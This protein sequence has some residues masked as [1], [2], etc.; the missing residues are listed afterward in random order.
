MPLKLPSFGTPIVLLTPVRNT[1]MEVKVIKSYLM[2]LFIASFLFSLQSEAKALH[3]KDS[4]V[5]K[6]ASLNKKQVKVN[7]IKTSG[8]SKKIAA[9]KPK[10]GKAQKKVVLV[11]AKKSKAA[12]RKVVR[13]DFEKK[14]TLNAKVKPRKELKKIAKME[15]AQKKTFKSIS[16]QDG[17]IVG[18]KAFC[19]TTAKT[20]PLKK[21]KGTRTLASEKSLDETKLK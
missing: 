5:K 20:Q 7:N 3:K 8:K 17:F 15:K 2:V 10:K 1:F 11:K 21:N 18:Q 9:V 19:A 6:S 16:C 4:A 12:P 13:L 14:E